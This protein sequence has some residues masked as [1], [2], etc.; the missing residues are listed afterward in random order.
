[1][2]STQFVKAATL[3]SKR[4]GYLSGNWT[5][6]PETDEAFLRLVKDQLAD[7]TPDL[8]QKDVSRLFVGLQNPTLPSA[9]KLRDAALKAGL[10]ISPQVLQRLHQGE[11][12]WS[13][14]I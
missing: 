14:G 1:M 10:S 8:L 7:D 11:T 13:F 12:V 2:E 5:P 4:I 6:D 3:L 9:L